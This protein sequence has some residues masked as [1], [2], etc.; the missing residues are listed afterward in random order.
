MNDADLLVWEFQRRHNTSQRAKARAAKDHIYEPFEMPD[1]SVA[2][3]A[4]IVAAVRR[5]FDR[6]RA[7]AG[8]R[9]RDEEVKPYRQKIRALERE[10]REARA[11]LEKLKG[12]SAS[13]RD[14]RLRAAAYAD[15]LRERGL[16]AIAHDRILDRLEERDGL[17]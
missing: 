10:L 8:R 15:V 6:A 5:R 11:E 14:E 16:L 12:L 9:P 1:F 2:E 13:L 17:M 7:N 4:E 3:R